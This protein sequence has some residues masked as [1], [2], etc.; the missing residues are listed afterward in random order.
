VGDLGLGPAVRPQL[1]HVDFAQIDG[2]I[3]CPAIIDR[4]RQ[5]AV[6]WRILLQTKMRPILMKIA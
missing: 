5:G 1:F 4:F 2:P 3:T 6:M